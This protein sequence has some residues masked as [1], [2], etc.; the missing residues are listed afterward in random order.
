MNS[1]LICWSCKKVYYSEEPESCRNCSACLEY[2]APHDHDSGGKC[3]SLSELD[4]SVH[5]MMESATTFMEE[6]KLL[7]DQVVKVEKSLEGKIP[8]SFSYCVEE[9]ENVQYIIAYEKFVPHKNKR[10]RLIYKEVVACELKVEKPLTDCKLEIKVWALQENRLKRFID[11]FA[12]DLESQRIT[13]EK[14]LG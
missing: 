8:F 9:K 14:M 10:R 4:T 7:G 3:T 6:V 2:R 12:K 13:L 1:T 5:S 11:A